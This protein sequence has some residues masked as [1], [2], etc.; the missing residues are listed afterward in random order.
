MTQPKPFCPGNVAPFKYSEGKTPE[1][2]QCSTCGN[3]GVKL[4]MVP[5]VDTKAFCVE[6]LA[7]QT[8]K[9]WEPFKAE[10]VSVLGV[11]TDSRH[12]THQVAWCVPYLPCENGED[13]WGNNFEAY[14]WWSNLPVQAGRTVPPEEMT[15]GEGFDKVVYV[16]RDVAEAEHNQ[17]LA[18]FIEVASRRRNGG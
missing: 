9:G 18:K 16:R 12:S 10:E 7:K 1:G 15:V 8:P 14:A 2:Y 3:T 17:Q 11:V 6:C 5:R 13:T 4:W